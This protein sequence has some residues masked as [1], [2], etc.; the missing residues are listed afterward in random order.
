MK[1]LVDVSNMSVT[2]IVMT[3]RA[4]SPKTNAFKRNH[5]LTSGQSVAAC[6]RG[7]GLTAR[8]SYKRPFTTTVSSDVLFELSGTYQRREI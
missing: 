4:V 3:I 8:T 2:K 5:H 7:L 6:K 1:N